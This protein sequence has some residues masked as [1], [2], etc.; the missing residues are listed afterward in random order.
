MK[1]EIFQLFVEWK[2]RENRKPLLVRGARQV[3]KTFTISE[4]ANRQFANSV[5]INL[6][7]SP[8]MKSI[9]KTNNPVSII[10]E[11]SVLK[12]TDII[13]GQTLLFIDEIQS[14]PDAIVCL[15][16]FYEQMPQLH[17]I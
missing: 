7:E 3:G 2:E 11:L 5:T 1:R 10:Q 6:E 12:R 16:Y 15:R 4:F 8:E 13:P 9:F 14:C 17:V